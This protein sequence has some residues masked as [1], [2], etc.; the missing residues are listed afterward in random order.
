MYWRHLPRRGTYCTSLL[1][2]WHSMYHSKYSSLCFKQAVTSTSQNLPTFNPLPESISDCSLPMEHSSRRH[3]A[4]TGRNWSLDERPSDVPALKLY[5][6]SR[7]EPSQPPAGRFHV[8]RRRRQGQK[9]TLAR[10]VIEFQPIFAALI[11]IL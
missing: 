3:A 2:F 8:Y 1:Q 10:A 5:L 11:T 9:R 7:A 4:I 6:H